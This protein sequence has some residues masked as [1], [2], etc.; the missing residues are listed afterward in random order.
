MN[1]LLIGFS[2][3]VLVFV[4]YILWTLN[5]RGLIPANGIGG[6]GGNNNIWKSFPSNYHEGFTSI[7][8]SATKVSAVDSYNTLDPFGLIDSSMDCTGST[9]SNTN[10]NI[11][12]NKQ[13]YTLL[14]TRG[15]NAKR[16]SA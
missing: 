6:V 9:Y 7:A 1:V 2:L 5:N 3:L 13:Q 15:G 14:T 8:D 16:T 11:C 10:G 4:F 12:L